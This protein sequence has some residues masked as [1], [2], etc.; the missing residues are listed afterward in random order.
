MKHD[1]QAAKVVAF[2]AKQTV[3]EKW[4]TIELTTMVSEYKRPGDS[5]IRSTRGKLVARYIMT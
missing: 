1:K 5:I 3:F 4:S 2:R